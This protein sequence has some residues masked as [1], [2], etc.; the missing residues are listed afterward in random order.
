LPVQRRPRRSIA[1]R[2]SSRLSQI[3]DALRAAGH[4][5]RIQTIDFLTI[6][7]LA[8]IARPPRGVRTASLASS[9]PEIPRSR[10]VHHSG[11]PLL[12]SHADFLKTHLMY[13]GNMCARV[14]FLS[15]VPTPVT[16]PR[17]ECQKIK[18][19]GARGLRHG[20]Q[21][22]MVFGPPL[23]APLCNSHLSTVFPIA[24]LPGRPLNLTPHP[25]LLPWDTVSATLMPTLQESVYLR[26][27]QL[28]S[29]LERS[30]T[31]LRMTFDQALHT[32]L[33]LCAFCTSMVLHFMTPSRPDYETWFAPN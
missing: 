13:L 17:T 5:S 19:D 32:S 23:P 22:E 15:I 11:G 26:F 2:A 21:H 33:C 4:R 30:P 27:T 24:L 1:R 29:P 31:M 25:L 10:S 6:V 28:P 8:K 9:N 18:L 16:F 3:S 20:A 7:G 14:Q 12:P